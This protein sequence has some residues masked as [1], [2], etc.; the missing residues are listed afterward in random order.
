V[1]GNE[2]SEKMSRATTDDQHFIRWMDAL[3]V[4]AKRYAMLAR[5]SLE[6]NS[7]TKAAKT[8]DSLASLIIANM[9]HPYPFP[10][11]DHLTNWSYCVRLG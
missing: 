10:M 2:E 3:A 1:A 8:T 7:N 4:V 6:Q 9:N 11:V 5:C